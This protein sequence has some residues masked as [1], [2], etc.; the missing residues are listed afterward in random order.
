MLFYPSDR[1]LKPLDGDLKNEE[2][3]DEDKTDITEKQKLL[4]E[5]DE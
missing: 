1:T 5:K 2:A 3:N 4:S